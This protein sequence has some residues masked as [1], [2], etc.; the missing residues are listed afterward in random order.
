VR[1]VAPDLASLTAAVHGVADE[2]RFSGVVR[3]DTPVGTYE[4]AFGLA[5]R[6]HAIANAASTRFSIASGT[7]GFTALTVMS[8]IETGELDLATTARSVLGPDLPLID[9]RVTVEHL[10]SHRSGIGDY[11]DEAELDDVNAYALPIPV[12]ELWGTEQ[13]LPILGGHPQVFAPGERFAY[14][15]SGYVV[16]ALIAERSSGRRF[17]DLVRSKVCEPAGLVSTGFLLSDQLGD[18]VA[19]GY[20]AADG[21]RTNVFHLP[22]MGSGDGGLFSTAADLRAF[23]S[24]VFD[25]RV[26]SPDAVAAMTEPCSDV[27]DEHLRYGMGFWLAPEGPSLALEGYDPGISFRSQHD[28][29]TGVTRTVAS[30][31][32]D[33]AW[34][35]SRALDAVFDVDR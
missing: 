3:V 30:N 19:L 33:G 22:V 15:N 4:R 6:R 26:V 29:A 18:D 8:L 23:W 17:E 35:M 27:P 25:G 24:A 5:D 16:L 32:S 9:E 14:N 34:P 7:K 2:T 21:L 28:P 1:T 20:L 10:L 31:T 11:L 13:Y 12:H